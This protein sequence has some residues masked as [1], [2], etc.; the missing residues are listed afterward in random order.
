MGVIIKLDD[1]TG[2]GLCRR[3]CPYGAVEIREKKAFF[4][5]FCTSCGSCLEVCP[6]GALTTDLPPRKLVDA[7]SYQGVFVFAE[8]RDGELNPVVPEL[9]GCAR[10]L[11]D[12]LDQGVSAVL[13]GDR[14]ERLAGTLFSQGADRVLLVEDLRLA[15]YHTLT[16]ARAAA[17][18][19]KNYK[20]SIF[21]LGATFVGRDLAPRLSRRL[22]LG[23]TADC[24]GLEIGEDGGLLQTRPAFGGNVMAV[25][26]S[27]YSRPQMATVRPGVMKALDVSRPPQGDLIRASAVIDPSDLSLRILELVRRPKTRVDFSLARVIVAGGRGVGGEPGFRLLE[28]LASLLGA[29]LG[30]TRVAVEEGWIPQERQI[31]QTGRTVRPELYL[32]CGISGAV[33]HRAGMTES[34]YVAAINRDPDAPIFKTADFRLVG[35]LHKIVP[36]IIKNLEAQG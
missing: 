31:G 6:T 16:Y 8:Q 3:V 36:A 21:L 12:S 2:C 5:E 22:N 34:R 30:G 29:E 11:A 28:K 13:I 7:A 27:P 33:Q 25:I 10:N 1:C 18:L 23:L 26:V 24:T 15:R 17:D 4:L 35:D 14:V 19:I 32:A 20:P 9:L